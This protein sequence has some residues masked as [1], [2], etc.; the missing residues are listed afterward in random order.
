MTPVGLSKYHLGCHHDRRRRTVATR[1]KLHR[2]QDSMLPRDLSQWISYSLE[3]TTSHPGGQTITQGG[4]VCLPPNL[5]PEVVESVINDFAEM[6]E[7]AS[8]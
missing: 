5:D 1:I 4:Y 8:C 7:E 6:E 3:Y 2:I